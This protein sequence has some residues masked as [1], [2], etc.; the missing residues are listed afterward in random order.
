[1]KILYRKLLKK[2]LNLLQWSSEETKAVEALK[3]VFIIAPVLALPTLEK[4]FHLFVTVKQGV[5]VQVLTQ[6]RGGEE[7]TCYFC[8]HVSQSCLSKITQM[9]A[10]SSCHGPPGGGELKADLWRGPD[11]ERLT[12][13]EEYIKS[14]RI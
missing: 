4:T 7:A 5:A 8:L 3:K 6:T 11:S 2:E 12:S 10:T 13:D 14:K 9:Y 1:M